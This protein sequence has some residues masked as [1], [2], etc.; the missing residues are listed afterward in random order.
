MDTY[1]L[2][3]VWLDVDLRTRTKTY[4][5]CLEEIGVGLTKYAN[6]LGSKLNMILVFIKVNKNDNHFG[7]FSWFRYLNPY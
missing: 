5:M 4:M 7:S 2:S 3:G 1:V 6:I